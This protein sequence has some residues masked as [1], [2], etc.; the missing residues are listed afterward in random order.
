MGVDP[1]HVGDELLLIRGQLEGRAIE[2]LAF[3]EP[4]SDRR[5][6]PPRRPPQPC[7][8]RSADSAVA[9]HGCHRHLVRPILDA[10]QRGHDDA[11]DRPCCCHGHRCWRRSPATR[12]RRSIESA[13]DRAAAAR[14]RSSARR[15]LAAPP[16]VPGRC[17]PRSPPASGSTCRRIRVEL[18]TELR[19][20]D[21]AHR[22]VDRGHGN[23]AGVD[24]RDQ[25]ARRR[26][27][28]G[29]SISR[30]ASA[31]GTVLCVAHPSQTPRSPGSPT[32][33]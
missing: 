11:R 30:P 6:P 18:E 17:A 12:R 16:R 28:A 5:R 19:A 27:W 2:A 20:Q 29:I 13:N 23:A 4:R 32:R 10:L 25:L 7:R 33:L 1:G 14:H 31:D 26:T 9:L 24:C 3:V 22:G 21:P 15:S 8:G